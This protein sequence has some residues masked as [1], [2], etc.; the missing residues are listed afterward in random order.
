MLVSN[1]KITPTSDNPLTTPFLVTCLFL[2]GFTKAAWRWR[3]RVTP[4][5]HP[6]ARKT[7]WL[8]WPLGQFPGL[9]TF[10]HSELREQTILV[11]CGAKGMWVPQSVEKL[12]RGLSRGGRASPICPPALLSSSWGP[13]SPEESPVSICFVGT[14]A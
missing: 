11:I 8:P 2:V 7:Q 6:S 14:G 12:Q 3:L 9:P 10:N 5:C 1:I 4:S 13:L